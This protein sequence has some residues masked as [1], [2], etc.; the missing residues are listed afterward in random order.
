[1]PNIT[2][3]IAAILNFHIRT[4]PL[5]WLMLALRRTGHRMRGGAR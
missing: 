4:H 1:M 3:A 5:S 2:A